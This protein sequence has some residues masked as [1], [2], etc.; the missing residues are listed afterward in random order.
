M[1]IKKI[2]AVLIRLLRF[3]IYTFPFLSVITITF[4]LIDSVTYTGFI[5]NHF[6]IDTVNTFLFYLF[7]GILAGA[8]YLSDQKKINNL[9][10]RIYYFLSKIYLVFLPISIIASIFFYSILS[11]DRDTIIFFTSTLFF[12]SRLVLANFVAIVF[13]AVYFINFNKMTRKIYLEYF[14]NKKNINYDKISLIL[15]IVLFFM[16][17]LTNI[18]RNLPQIKYNLK[19]FLLNTFYN[20]D[21]KMLSQIGPVYGY[22]LFIN[23]VTPESAVILHPK[24]QGQWGDVSNEG[25]TRYFIYPRN[26]V[27]EELKPEFKKDADYAMLIG[28]KKLT[29]A[30]SENQNRWPDF[31]IPSTE[32]ILY[33]YDGKEKPFVVKIDYSYKDFP[34]K[35]YWGLI[36]IDKEKVKW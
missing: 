19:F 7:S 4:C 16:F 22:Y 27:A 35:D 10:S 32:I 34:Y 13:L 33:S 24:Q 2:T 11:A 30:G 25:Y 6:I 36:K 29:F 8:T 5:G 12:P 9:L 20:Y 3:N 28:A 31:D 1:I 14:G 18:G 23:S 26:L 21:Q 15:F 17:L